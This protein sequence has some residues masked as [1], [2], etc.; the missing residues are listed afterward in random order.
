MWCR[1]P[2]MSLLATGG[3]YIFLS[4]IFYYIHFVTYIRYTAY[5]H[6]CMNIFEYVH[7]I[8]TAI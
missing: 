6:I 1:I 3:C 5:V 2:S 4:E 8:L 7:N